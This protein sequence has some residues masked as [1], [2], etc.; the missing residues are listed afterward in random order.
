MN[1]TMTR[2]IRC[3]P[4]SHLLLPR[5]L[6]LTLLLLI[7]AFVAQAAPTPASSLP[8]GSVVYDASWSW[9]GSPV[10][11]RVVH[12]NYN[13]VAGTITL[14]ATNPVTGRQ[15]SAGW[16]NDW[17]NVELRSWLNSTFYPAFSPDFAGIVQDTAVGWTHN[18]PANVLESGICTDRVFIASRTELGGTAWTGEGSVLAWLS[19]PGT[20][21]AR[22]GAVA[23]GWYW[24]RSGERAQYSGSW[25]NL[26]AYAV[27]APSGA[28]FPVGHWLDPAFGIVPL[29]NISGAAQFELQPDGRYLLLV[30]PML[31]LGTNGAAVA[32]GEAASL[33]KGTAF[34]SVGAGSYRDH[35]LSITNKGAAAL[36]ITG[37]ITNG[38]NPDVFAISDLPV[39]ISAHSKSNIT[40]R[41][42]PPEAGAYAASLIVSND[43][44][45]PVYTVNFSGPSAPDAAP[46]ISGTP[47]F[48]DIDEDDL[49]NPG[50]LIQTLIADHVVVKDGANPGVAVVGGNYTNG[51]WETTTDGGTWW[52]IDNPPSDT[53]ATLLYADAV[54]R[55]RFV[56]AANYHGEATLRLRAWDRTDGQANRTRFFHIAETGGQSAYSTNVA[57]AVITVQPLNDAPRLYE[58]T[59]A[60]V[61]QFDGATS[62]LSIPDLNY[63]QVSFTIEGWTYVTRV[64]TWNRFFDFGAGENQ[65]NIHVAFSEGGS[66]KLIAEIFPWAYQYWTKQ[67]SKAVE[68]FPLNQ[69]VHVAF[70]YNHPLQQFLVYC[71][72]A[73][74]AGRNATTGS[75]QASRNNCYFFRSNWGQ[76]ALT[77]GK[78]RNVRVWKN[79]RTQSQILADMNRNIA[80]PEDNLAALYLLNE[81]S[82]NQAV[83]LAGSSRTGSLFSTAWIPQYGFMAGLS[84]KKDAA[85]SKEFKVSD[86][87]QPLEDVVPT[88]AVSSNPGLIP[89]NNV[90]FTGTGEDRTMTVTPVAGQTGAATLT[91]RIDD[92]T[93]YNDYTIDVTVQEV[94]LVT[95]VTV[96]SPDGSTVAAGSTLQIIAA[97]NPANVTDVAWSIVPGTGNAEID[98]S[99]VLTGTAAG[100]VVVRATAN[101]GSGAYGE[102][103]ITVIKAAQ[104]IDFPTLGNQVATSVRGLAATAS[105]GLPVS[106]DVLSGPAL[107]SDGT[108]LSFTGAGTVTLRATQA[109]N[110]SYFS[111]TTSQTFSVIKA[112]AMATL[113]NMAQAYDGSPKA[114]TA[115]TTP[116]GLPVSLT[117]NGSSSAPTELGAYAVTGTVVHAIYQGS[118]DGTLTI[119]SLPAMTIETLSGQTVPNG[120]AAST[121]YGTDFG[122]VGTNAYKSVTLA[123]TNGGMIDLIVSGIGLS[124]HGVEFFTVSNL[125][126]RVTAGSVSNFVAHYAPSTLGAHEALLSITNDGPSAIYSLA[127]AGTALEAGEIGLIGASLSFEGRFNEAVSGEATFMVT[128]TGSASFSYT[129]EIRYGAFADWLAIVSPTGFASVAGEAIAHTGRVDSAGLNAGAYE[130]TNWVTSAEAV[131]SPAPMIVRLTVQK[132]T[133]HIEFAAI[134]QQVATNKIQIGAT[135]SSGLGDIAFRVVNSPAVLIDNTN[136]EF[137]GVGTVTLIA[138]Q[139]GN[140]NWMA[141]ADVTNAF[142]VVKAT[143]TVTL[144]NL[145]HTYDGSPLYASAMTTPGG[146]S[147]QLTYDGSEAAPSNAGS[148]AVT[149]TVVDATYE[150][151]QTGTLVVA[152]AA[153]AI[154]FAAIEPH[155]LSASVGLAATSSADLPVAFSAAEPGSLDGTNLTFTGVGDVEVVASQAGDANYLAAPDVTNVVKVFD[156]TPSSGSLTGGESVTVTNGSLGSGSDIAQVFVGGVPAP[157]ITDQGENWVTFDTPEFTLTGPMD[158]AIQS[159][160]LGET[161]LPKAYLVTAA[162]NIASVT[163][164]S[165]NRRGGYS[166]VIVG[167]NLSMG[168]TYDVTNVTLCGAGAVSID[169]VDGSTQIVVTAGAAPTGLGDVR[170]YSASFGETVEAD[171]FTYLML[172]ATLVIQSPYGVCVPVV[173]SYSNSFGAII[174]NYVAGPETHGTTQLACS[175]WTVTGHDIAG[176]ATTSMVMTI[177]NDAVLTWRWTTNYYLTPSAGPNGSVVQEAGWHAQGAVVALDAQAD[178]YYHFANWSGDASSSDNPL[179]LLMDAPKW[180]T[181]HF[182]ESW[183][184]NLPTPHR[185]LADY[186]ITSGFEE[187]V[188]NDP[189]NDRILTGYE[190]RS[191]T[192]PTNGD[193]Y[194]RIQRYATN[195]ARWAGGTGVVQYLEGSADGMST[196]TILATNLPPTPVTNEAPVPASSSLG[197]YR[198]RAAR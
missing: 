79:A 169:S 141:A 50:V 136:L 83:D 130:A 145:L 188:T 194:L 47:V 149:G 84:T 4:S 45:N 12:S 116:E 3:V 82:G 80:A 23:A 155:K 26:S 189:D 161:L 1:E 55:I 6:I 59:G 40:V 179:N 168:M 190:Y 61:A 90:V 176:G 126:S 193:S 77:Q 124:G 91:V 42:S 122:S 110:D 107:L 9:N 152:Q 150:G 98:A 146:L 72:G 184:T 58:A 102:M 171:A 53:N 195:T 104:T 117:Y 119:L 121:T 97:V 163:P 142:D 65:Y 140:S 92:G 32:S 27:D 137:T 162:G 166:V 170:V 87:E 182:A 114:A 100:T 57:A 52:T 88:A 128:N 187:A 172:D 153:Q 14:W 196:W 70:V 125:P 30:P 89:T 28:G 180:V 181:A 158:I 133:Q 63:N 105:S 139:A 15:F 37:W 186:G 33:V 173:G 49:N 175:G 120:S 75:E 127:L 103:T 99:G 66:G 192:C 48:P 16:W 21:A 36:L 131:N 76:D 177:T 35:I 25:Y 118:T 68:A 101:D 143:A 197:V 109:G 73:Q 41:F 44:I 96:T 93:E 38:A 165:G 113:S 24:T 19:D 134:G 129:N 34:P 78:L 74:K 10:G 144:T 13:G 174:T 115:A 94:P 31:V 111:A 85:V 22:R 183:T 167:T 62:Y 108:N 191:D 81:G 198:V 29:V 8:I 43:S 64:G 154:D 56:P 160:S 39:E 69:W 54:T 86:E 67:P 95:T 46:I 151:S 132:G 18:T 71:N 7:S 164:N 5:Y 159:T 17:P 135:A 148:Y 51:S 20:A 11:W 60:T 147:V 156:V 112:L 123:I 185:W 106:F 138:S 178:A 157:A 2:S